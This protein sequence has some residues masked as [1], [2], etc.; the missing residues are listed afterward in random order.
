MMNDESFVD[1][2]TNAFGVILLIT[3]FIFITSSLI[4]VQRVGK[5]KLENK[6]IDFTPSK[7]FLY[8]P[9]SRF[10]LFYADKMLEV[11]LNSVARKLLEQSQK[12]QISMPYGTFSL[13]DQL[14][15]NSKSLYSDIDHYN[16]TFDLQPTGIEKVGKNI[17]IGQE[18][19]F[20][21]QVKQQMGTTIPTFMVHKTGMEVFS[22][23][24]PY[25]MES[26]IRFRWHIIE[27]QVYFVRTPTDFNRR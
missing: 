3:L 7:R 24:F 13:G 6:T 15:R 12:S 26:Q 23:V 8:P 11:D 10:Y 21:A 14:A 25:L 27:E 9:Y 4:S 16:L 5:T 17:L 22:R 1:I 18:K 2:V 20:I 19:T